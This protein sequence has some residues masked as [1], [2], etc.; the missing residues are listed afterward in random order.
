MSGA[1]PPRPVPLAD[2]HSAHY[3]AAAREGTLLIQRCGECGAAQFYPRRHCT[4]CLAP[5]PG[6]E[7][8]S[9]RGRLHTFSVIHRSTNPEFAPDCPY[10]LAIVELDEGVRIS[11]RVVGAP[12]QALRCDARVRVSWPAGDPP[13]PVFVLDEE[14]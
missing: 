13:L 7:A 3:W 9:G 8:A 5:D 2:D 11:T 12:P 14:P 1:T 6:W 4:A 10:V